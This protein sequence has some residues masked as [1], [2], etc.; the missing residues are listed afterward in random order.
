MTLPK[1]PVP[2]LKDT[3]NKYLTVLTTVISPHE[4]HVTLRNVLEFMTPGAWGEKL[5]SHLLKR[6]SETDNWA[7]DWWLDNMYLQV[8]LPLPINSNPSITSSKPRFT[9][10]EEHLRFASGIVKDIVNFTEKLDA[11]TVPAPIPNQPMCMAQEYRLLSSYRRPGIPSDQLITNLG[12]QGPSFII[13]ARKNQFYR[14]DVEQDGVTL[15]EGELFSQLC[16]VVSA[17]ERHAAGSPPVGI[18]TAIDRSAWAEARQG[19]AAV[20]ENRSHLDTIENSLFILCLDTPL[21]PSSSWAAR[22]GK[23]AGDDEELLLHYGMHGLGSDFHS[24]NRWNDKTIQV[25][26]PEDGSLSFNVEHSPGEGMAMVHMFHTIFDSQRTCE[27]NE[28]Q[29]TRSLAEPIWLEW[30]T[31]SEIEDDIARAKEQVD[32]NVKN[33]DLCYELFDEFGTRFLKAQGVS[34]DNFV[35]LAFQLAYY[36][37]H[38]RMPM[39]YASASLRRF[40]SGRVDNIRANSPAVLAWIQAMCGEVEATVS[41]CCWFLVGLFVVVFCFVFLFFY[42]ILF[43]FFKIQQVIRPQD[44]LLKDVKKRKMEWCGH[45]SVG[46][47][48]TI[49]RGKEKPQ[50][51]K[52]EKEVARQYP[53]KDLNESGGIPES[54]VGQRQ[55]EK[56]GDDVFTGVV[57]TSSLEAQKQTLFQAAAEWLKR[58]QA[59]ALTGYAIDCHL[60]GLRE[61]ARELNVLDSI[62]L[63]SDPSFQKAFHFTLSTSQVGFTFFDGTPMSSHYGPVTPDGYGVPY[64]KYPDFIYVGV[65]SFIDCAET[66]S[67]EFLTRVLSS[68]RDMREN[69]LPKN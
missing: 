9:T 1:L 59:E 53:G 51:R 56:S 4:L 17:A 44:D 58:Y 62:P 29:D 43:L 41:Y 67:R 38:G 33:P 46:L 2:E 30:T 48:H 64:A 20:G 24:C 61:A 52:T 11:G 22:E 23:E 39:S 3:M 21:R 6:Q 40:R 49:S 68:F 65:T 18:L 42:L 50:T 35:Q 36:R 5:Q 69:C 60:I 7:T 37:M 26:L 16:K 55:V 25:L 45:A 28:G 10:K 12:K 66:D 8:R 27:R 19:L 31:T 54:R 57:M 15:S 14:V 63:F 47:P 34:P 13:V 32:R